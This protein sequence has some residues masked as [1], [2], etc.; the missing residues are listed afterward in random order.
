MKKIWIG[1]VLSAI[2]LAISGIPT[3]AAVPIEVSVDL[4]S[5]EITVSGTL[6][7]MATNH[8]VTLAVL[9]PDEELPNIAVNPDGFTEAI[10]D[11]QATYADADGSYQFEGFRLFEDSGEYLLRVSADNG[12]A[13]SV[14]QY[15]PSETQ[16][17]TIVD[18]ISGGTADEICNVLEEEKTDL[19][20]ITDISLY[21]SFNKSTKGI[22]CAELAGKQYLN[23]EEITQ[24][25]MTQS[26]LYEILHTTSAERLYQYLY[27]EDSGFSKDFQEAANQILQFQSQKDISVIS[28]FEQFSQAQKRTVLALLAKTERVDIESFYD[29]LKISIINYLFQ[30]VDNWVDISNYI[31]NYAED[32]LNTLE[33][34]RYIESPVK[35]NIDKS[36]IGRS[37]ASVEALCEY[38]NNYRTS[39]T[40]NAPGGGLG[41]QVVGSNSGGASMLEPAPII[42]EEAPDVADIT[43]PGFM[44]LSGYEW[45]ETE[46]MYLYDN[47]IVNGTGNN[48]FSPE[49]NV[50]REEFVKML[51]SAAGLTEQRN[52]DFEDVEVDSWAYP[53]IMKAVTA[54]IVNGVSATTFGFGEYITREDMAVLAARVL[55][56]EE[57]DNSETTFKDS[58]DISDY[59]L[60]AISA[61]VHM[62]ITKGYEDGTFGPKAFSTRAEA[63][64][65]I[66]RV[67]H[68]L[69]GAD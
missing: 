22:I 42:P 8:M 29:R 1:F 47:G 7:S 25:I 10:L 36:L 43:A 15:L 24:E 13:Y 51:V 18:K 4:E 59:A 54:G 49:Q 45:A 12:D 9:R 53:Y 27:L 26:A 52:Y 37:F 57:N 69:H 66:Y 64:V 39:V 11:F 68:V 62:G 14:T 38:I 34:D 41:P 23:L 20:K 63:A 55:K 3:L 46:I 40:G 35:T 17:Q 2:I 32:T 48:A 28:D 31:E 33:Y 61:M 60:T 19:L 58:A 21:Y 5:Y 44:D 50:T 65:V 16:F 67:I 30:S 6:D 56:Y